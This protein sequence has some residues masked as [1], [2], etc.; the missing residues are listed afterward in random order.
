MLNEAYTK[1]NYLKYLFKF[2]AIIISIFLSII[3]SSG[4]NDFSQINIVNSV[5]NGTIA[6]MIGIENALQI[7]NKRNVFINTKYKF[8]KIR[9]DIEKKLLTDEDISIEFVQ[10]I[11]SDYNQTINDLTFDIP[12]SIIKKTKKEYK[13]TTRALPMILGD[14]KNKQMCINN[15]V[16]P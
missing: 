9:N 16:L 11:M 7:D 14:D 4:L 3:N 13:N 5:L 8:D 10:N 6:L 15:K 12:F 1:L 2:P